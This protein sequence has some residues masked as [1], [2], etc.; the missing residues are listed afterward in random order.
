[1]DG[2]ATTHRDRWRRVS[3]LESLPNARTPTLL[4][5]GENDGRCPRGQSEEVFAHLIRYTDTP[6]ELVL[7]PESAH[8]E[9]ESGRPSNR[10][11]YH[12]RI[13][14][15]AQ[16]WVAQAQ[17]QERNHGHAAEQD[18]RARA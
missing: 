7:Y 8:A 3:V 10:I 18:A 15:W 12:N 6:V 5:Q 1:M 2:E 14:A 11:D 17:E 16:R 13:V 4:L 9:A